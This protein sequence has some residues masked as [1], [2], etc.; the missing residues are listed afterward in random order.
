MSAALQASKRPTGCAQMI[1]NI[2]IKM[3]KKQAGCGE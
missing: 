2:K 3:K 1:T